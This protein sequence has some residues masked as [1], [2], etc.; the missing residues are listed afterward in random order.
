MSFLAGIS[1]Q[2]Y[3]STPLPLFLPIEQ[4]GSL[5]GTHSVVLHFFTK[6]HHSPPPK[7]AF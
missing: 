4:K 1:K 7:E 3:A 5:K 2:A 6:S